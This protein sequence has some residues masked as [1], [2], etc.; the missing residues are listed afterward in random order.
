VKA[1]AKKRAMVLET[2]VESNDDSNGDGGKSNGKGDK[3]GWEAR[4]RVMV[5]RTVAGDDEGYGNGNEGAK[6]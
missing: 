1:N 2:L 4:M 5:A 6:R 3:G